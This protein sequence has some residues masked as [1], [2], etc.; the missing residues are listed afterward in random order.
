M[1]NEPIKT[2]ETKEG[3]YFALGG[4]TLIKKFG[5][6]H[7]PENTDGCAVFLQEEFQRWIRKPAEESCLKIIRQAVKQ[8]NLKTTDG[9]SL[10]FQLFG[11]IIAQQDN[12]DELRAIYESAVESYV[13]EKTRESLK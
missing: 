11:K 10:I 1:D 4:K 8:Y 9:F 3:G 7:L 6:N 12:R 5:K 2:R 13:R